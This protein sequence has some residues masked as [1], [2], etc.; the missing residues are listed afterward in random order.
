MSIKIGIVGAGQ[1]AQHFIPLFNAHPQVK[2]VL[3]A[4]LDEKKRTA[5]AV[6]YGVA[7]TCATLEDVLASDV[8]A[9]ALFT[10]HWMHGP[11]AMQAL[12]AGKHVYSAVPCAAS[13]EETSA[14]LEEISSMAKRNSEGA[15][16]AK[17]IASATRVAA[18]AGATEVAAMNEAMEAIKNSSNGIAKIIKTIDDIAFQTN[19]L[20]SLNLLELF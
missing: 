17:A 7:A 5:A 14:S 11:Q 8:D 2:S 1:F 13:I 15:Q 6:K 12:R 20:A 18:D 9:V 3:L 10:Q 4:D 16:Q 19:L